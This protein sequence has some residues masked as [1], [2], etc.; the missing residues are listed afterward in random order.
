MSGSAN[1][2]FSSTYRG[3]VEFIPKLIEH[4]GLNE[5]KLP[6]VVCFGGSDNE[7]KYVMTDPL[8][9]QNI[10]KFVEDIVAGKA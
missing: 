10:V 2:T 5:T 3:G 9:Y 7:K 6:A 1:V 8:T 4:F